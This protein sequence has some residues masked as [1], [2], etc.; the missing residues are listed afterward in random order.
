MLL[1]RTVL[2]FTAVVAE[3]VVRPT[4]TVELVWLVVCV[5]D[6]CVGVFSDS[7]SSKSTYAK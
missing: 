1:F 2:P 7:V 5:T 6:G 3:G 4:W